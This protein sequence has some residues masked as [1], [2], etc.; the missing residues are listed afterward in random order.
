MLSLLLRNLVFT[1]LQPGLVAGLIPYLLLKA[2]NRSCVPDDFGYWQFSGSFAMIAGFLLMITCI[3]Q[4]AFEGKGTLSPLDPTKSL[5]V[6]GFYGRSRN[7]M[8]V[9]VTILLCGEAMFC[10]SIVLI[11]YTAFVFIGFNLF[12]AFHEEPRLSREFG[13]DWD[14]YK[15]QVRRWL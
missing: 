1:I 8:Y 13:S 4:F 15:E 11:G 12:I 9:G 2:E 5:V 3:L 7:P 10:Q 6:R 14:R